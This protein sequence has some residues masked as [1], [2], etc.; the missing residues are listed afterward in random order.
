MS[1]PPKPIDWEKVDNLLMAG[2]TG[3]EIAPHFDIHPDTFYRRVNEKY[4]VG[5]T[6]YCS[7]KRQKGDSLLREKQFQLAMNGDK[8][9]L[10]WLGKNRLGQ[11][12][13]SDNNKNFDE[14]KAS[15]NLCIAELAAENQ[16]LK[17][18]LDEAKQQANSI[19]SGS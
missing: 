19:H 13:P 16:Q 2:C 9:L 4:G 12:E 3:T 8:G 18:M 7:I 5:F 14:D 6:E 10:I 17:K 15:I 11:K 1:C